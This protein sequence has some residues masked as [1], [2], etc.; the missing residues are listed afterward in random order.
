MSS[1]SVTPSVYRCERRTC[2]VDLQTVTHLRS[3]K[4]PGETRDITRQPLA[5]NLIRAALTVGVIVSLSSCGSRGNSS[6]TTVSLPGESATTSVEATTTEANVPATVATTPPTSAGTTTTTM[7]AATAIA[8]ITE[9]WETFFHAGTPLAER[10][11]LLEDG[12]QY[13]EA[14]TVRATDPL[15]AQASAVVHDVT[16][17]DA[18]HAHVT[19]DVILGETVALPAAEGNAVLQDGT[20]KVSAESFCSLIALG[21]S[22]PIPGCS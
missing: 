9:N 7:E 2:T 10:E 16:L 20:W 13:V 3:L 1:R 12:A 14:L 21:A 22:E 18:T 15:Q 4:R 17:N 6:E 8:Q 19:Y 11:A 5:P